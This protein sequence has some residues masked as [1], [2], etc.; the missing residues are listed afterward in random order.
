[1]IKMSH[2]DA[3]KS[4]HQGVEFGGASSSL[5]GFGSSNDSLFRRVAEEVGDNGGR[6]GDEG[7]N[8]TV[9]LISQPRKPA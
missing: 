1:M 8:L 4:F 3:A 6:V 5:A 9:P 7:G 2:S